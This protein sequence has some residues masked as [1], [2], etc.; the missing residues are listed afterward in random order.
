MSKTTETAEITQPWEALGVTTITMGNI[1]LMLDIVW[2]MRKKI[3]V[4]LMGETGVGKTPIV[5][6]WA[7]SKGGYC[8]P[9]NFSAIQADSVSMSIFN[10]DATAYDF[11]PPEALIELNRR[12]E[13]DGC[14]VLFLDEW[15]RGDKAVVNALFTLCDERRIH[16]FK[17]HDNVLVVAAMNPS[18]GSYMV[19]QA[20]RDHAVR[21]RLNF[22]YVVPDHTTWLLH[23]KAENFFPDVLDFVRAVPTTFY[24]I[25]ARDA[26]RAFPCPSNWEKVSDICYTAKA[27]DRLLHSATRALIAGQIGHTTAEIFLAYLE[28]ANTVIAPDA[29]LRDY[30]T[31]GRDRV[32]KLLGAAIDKKTGNMV[33]SSSSAIRPDV[34]ANLNEGIAMTLFSEKSDVETISENLAAYLV[35][36]PMEFFQ[37]FLSVNVGHLLRK[38]R[39]NVDYMTKLNRELNKHPRFVARVT[40]MTEKHASMSQS[41]RA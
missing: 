37:T 22:M 24:D 17:L 21:K 39:A 31:T 9:M 1:P 2:A 13:Q 28:D 11:V 19:N 27:Q 8:Y 35:D 33:L 12:A 14:A 16:R 10:R 30:N 26:G 41:L 29:V 38:D 25:A 40:S 4:C 36:L 15:N 3:T 18:T 6:Q 23:G 7:A 20:E 5:H 32:A 34:L